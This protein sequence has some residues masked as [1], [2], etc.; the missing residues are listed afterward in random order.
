MTKAK[1]APVKPVN[2]SRKAEKKAKELPNSHVKM[3][4]RRHILPPLAG[5][6]VALL[7]FGFFN[8]E[9]L[10]GKIAYYIYSR[11][12]VVGNLDSITAVSAISKD[13]PEQVIINKINVTA[14]VIYNQKVIDEDLFQIALQKGV[15]HY[16]NTA[17]P[18]ETGNVVIFGHSSGR[19][20]A[21]GDHK[22]VFTLLDKMQLENKIF[23]DYKGTRYI[24]KVTNISV[25]KPTDVS[26]LNQG[27]N[28]ILTL[29]TCTPVG[30]NTNRLIIRAQQI[31]PKVQNAQAS[32]KAAELPA[33]VE[34]TLPSG[35]ASFW[36]NL[37]DLF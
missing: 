11:H 7:V 23:L 18:G 3:S 16:P 24:Y 33:E 31:S 14:P 27:G 28:N 37:R 17:L 32:D 26:V 13:A 9:I 36:D 4:F 1:P 12:V 19:W 21:P 5:L 29:I 20:W 22:Y 2:L 8:A 15:V 34:S 35:S 10:S 25:V 30:M 6:I